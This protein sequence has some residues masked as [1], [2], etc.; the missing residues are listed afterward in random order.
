[1]PITGFASSDP[2]AADELEDA[3]VRY[4]RPSRLEEPL[5][6]RGQ[7]AQ[8]AAETLGLH[9]VGDL[10]EHLPRDRREARTIAELA[11]RE[12]ATIVVEVRSISSR[13]V[14][15]RGMRPIV[16][17]TVADDT[18]VL[19]VAFFNQPWLVSRYPPGTRLVL[20]GRY[21]ARNR[22][23]VQSQRQDRRSHGRRRGRRALPG[24]RRAVV[25]RDPGTRSRACLS[26]RR[27]ARAAAGGAPHLTTTSRSPRRADGRPTFPMPTATSSGSARLAF[28]E[29]LL[30]QLALVR[31]RRTREPSATAP[32]LDGARELSGRW[33]EELLPF[34][35]TGD[36]LRALEEIDEDLAGQQADAAAADGRG[37]VGQDGRRAVRAAASGRARLPGRR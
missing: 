1:M 9:T 29:L 5:K 30:A 23:S 35:P 21:Q 34:E 19:K 31:R 10:L 12:S 14:R 6:V 11:Q 17:A 25:D 24:H 37:R 3:P 33:L 8:Q 28:D 36:Q 27:R 32:V 2:L 26:A 7:K 13:S 22:F 20:H 15:R 18:G 16:E 4:P